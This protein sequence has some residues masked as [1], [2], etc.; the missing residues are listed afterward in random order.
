[1]VYINLGLTQIE[2]IYYAV[3][4]SMYVYF[5]IFMSSHQSKASDVYLTFYVFALGELAI[6]SILYSMHV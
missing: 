6:I 1:M 2:F 3:C 5:D 4:Y